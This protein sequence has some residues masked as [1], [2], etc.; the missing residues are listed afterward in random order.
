MPDI[1]I[2]G[3]LLTSLDIPAQRCRYSVKALQRVPKRQATVSITGPLVGG[4]RRVPIDHGMGSPARQSHQV[5]FLPTRRQPLAGTMCRNRCGL[6]CPIPASRA[7]RLIT[8]VTPE[9]VGGVFR[10]SHRAGE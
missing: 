10:P 4:A 6:T 3:G 5:T 7:R 9:T 8:W 2:F 1:R